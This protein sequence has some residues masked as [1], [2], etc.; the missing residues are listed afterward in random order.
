MQITQ[1]SHSATLRKLANVFTQEIT[2][3]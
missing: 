1:I 3:C 2:E